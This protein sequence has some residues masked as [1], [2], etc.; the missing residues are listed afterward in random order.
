MPLKTKRSKIN[1]KS[2]L[3]FG[4]TGQDGSLLAKE[5]LNKNFKVFGVITSKFFS[6]INLEKLSILKKVK[7]FHCANIDKLDIGFLIRKTQC[8]I[9]YLLSG[10]SSVKKSET[11]KHETILSNNLILIEVLEF[12][13]VNNLKD[14]KIFNASSGEIFGDNVGKNNEDSPLNPLSYYALAKSISLEI[15]RSYRVQFKLKIYNGILFNHE[16]HLRPKTYVIKKIINGVDNISNK[17]IKKLTLGN[18]NVYRD[19]G[20]A[21]EYVKIIYKIISKTKPDD[22][23]IATGKTTKLDHLL[24]KVFNHYK[25][26]KKDY[27]E[28]SN[29]LKRILEPVRI[30]ANIQKLKKKIKYAPKISVNHIISMMIENKIK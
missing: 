19:W 27:L 1:K 12:I 10:I 8:S 25:L 13:R 22:Y 17:K 16:S 9:I 11:H 28:K 15:C 4:I 14:I 26:K 23:I 3:I 18:T 20:W 21:P 29:S 24:T 6:P 30:A 5:Y 7:L 2:V